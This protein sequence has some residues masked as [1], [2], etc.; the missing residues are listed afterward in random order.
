MAHEFSPIDTNEKFQSAI[1]YV[2]QNGLALAR[3]VLGQTMTIDTICFFTHSPEEYAFL[4]QA[5]RARGSVSVLSHGPTLYVDSDFMVAD[6]RIRIFGVRQPDPSRPEVGYT[7]YPVT[8][9]DAILAL[10]SPYITEIVSGRGQ[11]LLQLGHPDFDVLGF[12]VRAE[13]HA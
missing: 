7:D 1:E 12:V 4:E 2:A 9:Y 10:N 8:D 6:Q 3:T 5:V 11:E 13:D